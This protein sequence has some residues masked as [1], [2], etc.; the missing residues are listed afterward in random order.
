M[1][2]TADGAPETAALPAVSVVVATRDRPQLLAEALDAILAQRYAGPI[3][4]LAVFDQAEPDT[5]LV[6]EEPDR[7]V[8]VLRNARTPGLAGARNTGIEAATGDYVAFCDDDDTW[9]PEKLAEQIGALEKAPEAVV[10]V[11]GIVVDFRGRH[12]VRVPRAEE[13]N[14]RAL[15]T[16]RV[17]AAHPSSYVMRASRLPEVGLV[18]E[19]IPG[20]YG[21]DYDWLLRWVELGPAAVVELPLVRVRWGASSYFADRWQ[22]MA[23]AMAFLVDKHPEF[24]TSPRGM[25]YMWGKRAFALAAAGNAEA[26][27]GAAREAIGF[28]PVEPRSY[29]ALLVSWG[30]LSPALLV[31][32]LNARGKGI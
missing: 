3:E 20:S 21:E 8:R 12:I 27:R 31:R 2:G 19:E 30:L 17:A 9:L 24:R 1:T 10:S 11:T 16:G 4:V 14:L 5:G 25:A 13:L 18:D 7:T 32:V 28:H 29:L 6:R 15:Y 23:D 22:M 26:A